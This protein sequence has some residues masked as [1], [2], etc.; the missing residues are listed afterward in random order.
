M[1]NN[2]KRF[3][4]INGNKGELKIDLILNNIYFLKKNKKI[5]K[6]ISFIK[7]DIKNSYYELVDFFL[8]KNYSKKYEVATI[9]DG[10]FVLKTI[11]KLKK[12]NEI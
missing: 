8:K 10:V 4:T 9:E 12:S 2:K 11:E 5:W 1:N 3:L 7:N 6:N